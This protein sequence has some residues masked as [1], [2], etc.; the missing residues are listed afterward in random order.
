MALIR[1]KQIRGMAPSE[2]DSKLAELRLELVKETGNV[3]MGKPTKNTS[4]IGELKKAIA[5]I[6]TV[7]TEAASKKT[8]VK[9]K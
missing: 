4:K 3:R 2:L 5:R 7:K 8:G 6:N 9:N 1:T